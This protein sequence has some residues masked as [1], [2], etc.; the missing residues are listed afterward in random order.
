MA[1][2]DLVDILP[3]RITYTLHFFH[4]TIMLL[5]DCT[6]LNAR[7]AMNAMADGANSKPKV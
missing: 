7:I 6:G 3:L 1:I 5:S 4:D 2:G